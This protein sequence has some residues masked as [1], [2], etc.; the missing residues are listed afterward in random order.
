MLN[1]PLLKT[2]AKMLMRRSGLKLFWYTLFYMLAANAVAYIVQF[3]LPNLYYYLTLGAPEEL[4]DYLRNIDAPARLIPVAIAVVLVY[5]IFVAIIGVGYKRTCLMAARGEQIVFRD[6]FE[7]FGYWI[8]IICLRVAVGVTVAAATLCF[9][10]PG[11]I[12]AYAYSMVDYILIDNPDMGVI[13]IMRRSRQMMKG[14]KV[15]YFV[16]LLSYILWNI[17]VSL[18]AVA[19]IYVMPYITVGESLYYEHLCGY[20][21]FSFRKNTPSDET[22]QNPTDTDIGE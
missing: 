9:I 21:N 16:F 3:R 11:V 6:M 13:A 20:R 1:R 8:K 15:E 14:H 18:I 12:L 4:M 10:I 7:S 2:E 5:N 19:N 17:L 22:E